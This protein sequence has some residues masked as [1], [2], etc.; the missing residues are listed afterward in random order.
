MLGYWW[1][2]LDDVAKTS[3]LPLNDT[4][5]HLF[6][7]LKNHLQKFSAACQKRSARF[8][9]TSVDICSL[10]QFVGNRQFDRL[11]IS[12]VVD[13]C[14]LGVRQSLQ[15]V[16]GL[17][18]KTNTHSCVI[19]LFMNAIGIVEQT[20]KPLIIQ[21]LIGQVQKYLPMSSPP[22][23][24]YDATLLQLLSAADAFLPFDVWFSKYSEAYKIH[25]EALEL[26]FIARPKNTVISEW[27]WRFRPKGIA[28]EDR[29]DLL[30]LLASGCSGAERYVEWVVTKE[31]QS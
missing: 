27:P 31:S 22:K 19:T 20:E 10:G 15:S 2:E 14:Y 17:L 6:F 18:K 1:R 25:E 7:Y 13:T 5:G 30:Q 16:T 28:Q 21:D 29:Q 23:G 26:N 8:E 12:N 9:V 24:R 4:Y 11:E 3:R